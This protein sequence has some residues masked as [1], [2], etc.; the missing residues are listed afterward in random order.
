MQTFYLEHQNG[1]RI[2]INAVMLFDVFCR[3]TLFLYL[4]SAR[5]PSV[6]VVS[7]A[8]S[9]ML[10]IFGRVSNP[11][12]SGILSYPVST[13]ADFRGSRKRRW[14]VIP[15]VYCWELLRSHPGRV[16]LKDLFFQD[17]GMKLCNTVDRISA[18][19]SQRRAMEPVRHRSLPSGGLFPSSPGYCSLTWIRKRR[20]ISSTI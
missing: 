13:E 8:S 19:D 2:Y 18:Y 12:I 16:F 3:R 17:L 7:S 20:L 14:L 15:F 10:S 9:A 1:V 5:I 4:I 11:A 6:P